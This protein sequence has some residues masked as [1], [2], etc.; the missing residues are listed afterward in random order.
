[1]IVSRIAGLKSAIACIDMIDAQQL[2]TVL[3]PQAC[4]ILVDRNI[5]SRQLAMNFV[6]SSI[7]IMKRHHE[8]LAKIPVVDKDK[9]DKTAKTESGQTSAWTSW[10]VE[11]L[12]KTFERVTTTTQAENKSTTLPAMPSTESLRSNGSAKSTDLQQTP[13]V[14]ENV[15]LTSKVSAQSSIA[16]DQADDVDMDQMNSAWEDDDFDWSDNI[17]IDKVDHA[18]I[19]PKQAKPLVSS[20]TENVSSAK[21]ARASVAEKS[22]PSTPYHEPMHDSKTIDSQSDRVKSR[23]P[24]TTKTTSKKAVKLSAKK[25]DVSN[26]GDNWDD[27]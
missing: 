11:G 4:V 27:F 17:D 18:P 19:P 8:E 24:V 23:E 9:E 5:E 10:A 6:E 2:S 25:L 15:S 21:I 16:M 13:K 14:V 7:R 12:S 22:P 3:L 26:D 20:T 1:M